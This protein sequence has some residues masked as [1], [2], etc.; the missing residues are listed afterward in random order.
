MPLNDTVLQQE[1][2]GRKLALRRDLRGT[3]A[4]YDLGSRFIGGYGLL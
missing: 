2:D 4:G 3:L 1:Y